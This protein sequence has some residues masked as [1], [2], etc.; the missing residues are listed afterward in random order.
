MSSY[1]SGGYLIAL[2]QRSARTLL[3]EGKDDKAIIARVQQEIVA[4]AH[5]P[6]VNFVIDTCDIAKCSGS[7]MRD[8]VE[9]IHA[10]AVAQG[11]PLAALVD[12]EFREF[13]LTDNSTR[14]ILDCHHVL[15][16]N[17]YWTRGHSIENYFLDVRFIVSFLKFQFPENLPGSLITAVTDHFDSVIV[18]AAVASLSARD[19]GLLSKTSGVCRP[20]HWRRDNFKPK[21]SDDAI[22]ERF[23]VRAATPEQVAEFLTKMKFYRSSLHGLPRLCQWLSHG[24]F[25]RELTWTAVASLAEENGFSTTDVD[26]IGTGFK[27]PKLR[28]DADLWARLIVGNSTESPMSLWRWFGW[29]PEV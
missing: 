4:D 25:G 11:I 16:S 6:N 26:A 15:S 8:A 14:D 23:A 12:R 3:V 10:S 7:G 5:A 13:E 27:D 17:M 22:A 9:A 21:L 18:E 28:H 19:A 20:S 1:S 24:H 29:P 2:Q